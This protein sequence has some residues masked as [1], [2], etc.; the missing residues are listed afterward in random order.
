M[1]A[2]TLEALKASIRKWRENAAVDDL[3]DANTGAKGCPLC[4]VFYHNDCAGCP[5]MEETGEECCDDTPYIA[6]DAALKRKDL[7]AFKE[8]SL[9]EVAFLESLLP[10]GETA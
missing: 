3:A 5:V 7:P 10:E 1:N 8:A 6:A 2:E 4:R 9:E